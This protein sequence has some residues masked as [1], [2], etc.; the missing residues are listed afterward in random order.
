MKQPP[1]TDKPPLSGWCSPMPG[2]TH[3]RRQHLDCMW[4][5]CRCDEHGGHETKE[6]DALVQG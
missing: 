3:T 4:D 2:F 1:T 6:S 5:G